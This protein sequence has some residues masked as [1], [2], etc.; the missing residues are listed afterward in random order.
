MIVEEIDGRRR[1]LSGRDRPG[2]GRRLVRVPSRDGSG[3]ADVEVEIKGAS[4]AR[5][6]LLGVP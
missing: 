6:R 1:S 2:G 3:P 4:G 5:V